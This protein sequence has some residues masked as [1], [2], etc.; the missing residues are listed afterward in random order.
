MRLPPGFF[1]VYRNRK[2]NQRI[3]EIKNTIAAEKEVVSREEQDVRESIRKLEQRLDQAET[4]T[5]E[6]Q[7]AGDILENAV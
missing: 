2:K 6:I 5:D 3:E 7:E 4:V 1:L